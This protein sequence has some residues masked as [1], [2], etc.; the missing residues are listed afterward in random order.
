[1]TLA[2]TAVL[3][4]ASVIPSSYVFADFGL[5]QVF[6]DNVSVYVDNE[7]GRFVIQTL[8]GQPQRKTDDDKPLLFGGSQPKTSFTTFRIDGEDF[9]YGNDYGFVGMDSSFVQRPQT[10]GM[11][12]HSVW[13]K[14]GIE[15]TQN[16]TLV[17]D[18][19]NE[20]LG[21]VKITYEVKN[22][23]ASA[24]SVGSRILL[25]T[26]MGENDASLVT[27]AGNPAY[28]E[29]ETEVTGG[30]VPQYWRAVE[31]PN[32]WF[33][34]G[35]VAYGML[36]GWGNTIPD[37]LTVAHWQGIGQ[38]KWE[39][40]VDSDVNFGTAANKY[41]SADSAVAM[42]WNPQSLSPGESR[43]YETYYGV[44]TII[45]DG[46]TALPYN[47]VLSAPQKLTVNVDKDDYDDGTFQIQLLIDNTYKRELMSGVEAELLLPKELQLVSGKESE[48]V[49]AI[50]AG[51]TKIV[52]WTVRAMPQQTYKSV[53]YTVNVS[54][55]LHSGGDTEVARTGYVLLPSVAGA[56]PLV[57]VQDLLPAKK[58]TNDEEQKL[59]LVGKGFSLFQNDGSATL[60]LNRENDV[61]SRTF[62]LADVDLLDDQI[63]IDLADILGGVPEAGIYELKLNTSEF[64]TYTRKVEFTD[65]VAYRSRNY[66]LLAVT[67]SGTNYKLA[68]LEDEAGLKRLADEALL[69]FRGTVKEVKTGEQ[70]DIM[71]GSTIN[72]I[73]SFSESAD[74]ENWF[75][76]AQKMMISQTDN[77]IEMTGMGVLSIPKF[78]FTHGEFAI[79]LKNGTS[80]S[81]NPDQ[82]CLN[83]GTFPKPVYQCQEKEYGYTDPDPTGSDKPIQIEWPVYSWL[84][85]NKMLEK[86]P[87]TLKS[88]T[89]GEGSVSFGGSVALKLGGS[90]S[91]QV[92]HWP[93]EDAEWP[94]PPIYT[95]EVEGT[96][97]FTLSVNMQE[98]R[99]GM[100]DNQQFGLQGVIANGQ[101]GMPDGLVPGLNFGANGAVSINTFKPEY[102]I[103]VGASFEV[104]EVEGK[105]GLRFDQHSVPIIDSFV[106]AVGGQPGI[107]ITPATPVAYLTKVGGGFEKLYDTA[108]GNY[109]VIPPL[110]LIL[111]G[112][113]DVAKVVEADDMRLSM[114][115]QNMQFN[116][117]FSIVKFP[118]LNDVFGQIAI[119]DST[120][121]TGVDVQVG[122]TLT[123]FEIINGKVAAV[124]SY[125]SRRSGLFGPVYVA[126]KGQVVFGLPKSFP[127]GGGLKFAG[128]EAELSSERLLGRMEIIG[129]KIGAA[130]NWSTGEV[131]LASHPSGVK[132]ASPVQ[133]ASAETGVVTGIKNEMVYDPESGEQVG[134][135]VFGTNL[136]QGA[137]LKRVTRGAVTI[138]SDDSFVYT[139]NVS[140]DN[141]YAIF[142]LKYNG[143]VP[144]VTVKTPSGNV[145]PLIEEQRDES[146]TITQ[147]GNFR[148][149]EIPAEASESG[150]DEQWMYISALGTDAGGNPVSGNAAE[151]GSWMIASDQPLEGSA[152]NVAVM[153]EIGNVVASLTDNR[154]D[155]TWNATGA[156]GKKVALYI[157][158]SDQEVPE[159]TS[160]QADVSRLMIA[161]DN[162]VLATAGTASF[163]L[164]DTL[165]TGDYYVKAVLVDGD[166]NLHST[167]ST[168][169]IAY[170]N[171]AAPTAPEPPAVSALGNGFIQ[172]DWDYDADT[173]GAVAGF[174]LQALDADSKP[175]AGIGASLVEDGERRTANIGGVFIASE[176]GEEL[177]IVPGNTYKVAVKAYNLVGDQKVYG[178]S[179]ISESVYIPV[180]NPPV[181][182]LSLDASWYEEDGLYLTNKDVVNLEFSADQ[183]VHADV[184]VNDKFRFNH[185]GYSWSDTVELQEDGEHI[186]EILVTNEATGDTTTS[187]LHVQRDMKAPDLMIESP[188]RVALVSGS[189]I[190]VRGIAEPASVVTVNGEP[191]ELAPNG[192]FQTKLS[193]SGY[194][195][196]TVE[197]TATDEAGNHSEY[198]ADV[199]A[200]G[201]SFD[202]IEARIVGA[203]LGDDGGY[204]LAPGELWDMQV[205]SVSA[206]G[207]KRIIEDAALDWRTLMGEAYGHVTADGQLDLQLGIAEASRSEGE[208]VVKVSYP[209]SDEYMLEDALVIKVGEGGQEGPLDPGDPGNPGDHD[210]GGGSSHT[211][212]SPAS[213]ID[214]EME[215]L[216]RS[217]IEADG[218]FTYMDGVMLSE[219]GGTII[220]LDEQAVISLFGS[221]AAFGYG[222]AANPSAYL[223]GNLILLSDVY[224][225]RLSEPIN[226]NKPALLA[227]RL[228]EDAGSDADKAG[229]YWYN[230]QK[231]RWEYVGGDHDTG[232]AI[233]SAELPYF[234]KYALL[235][236]PERR[237]FSDI[238]GRWSEHAV[239]RLASIDVI[240]GYETDEERFFKPEQSITRQEF[241]KLLVEADSLAPSTSDAIASY[242]DADQVGK[243]AIP[244]INAALDQDWLSGVNRGDDLVLDPNREITRAEAAVLIS[245]MLGDELETV[246]A[247]VSFVDGSAVPPWA[248]KAVAMMQ[249]EK[250]ISGYPDGT[251]RPNNVITREEAAQMIVQLLDWQYDQSQK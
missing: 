45:Y 62:S 227:I 32:Q 135:L 177:G 155:V 185:N 156:E 165:P 226:L 23:T 44:G 159:L 167:I 5:S 213:S 67:K 123:V 68:P 188:S 251:F 198:Q 6:N 86:L 157:T 39:Y 125:D 195:S 150:L 207:V 168:H 224:D 29:H 174:A 141:P 215:D 138:A 206:D 178:P 209:L 69:V 239:Y 222:K 149:Q 133:I 97:P 247:A 49:G 132:G 30:D 105:L 110:T 83:T 179:V 147:E 87:V 99:F 191:V 15:V 137:V 208:L 37:R 169:P 34:S 22:T 79:N 203:E 194:F 102:I 148:L 111:I 98:A 145:Y 146:G 142:Q 76:T 151:S 65:D 184:F 18:P 140:A 230:E 108:M 25:D 31:H 126:G 232:T 91:K 218:Y 26:Q 117:D 101:V 88:V 119:A 238:D 153:P 75:G 36:N 104:V 56:P 77:G 92:D 127:V 236:N 235:I 100:L 42:Y 80:Y 240:H 139:L 161:P 158:D 172:V 211:G 124:F 128:V 144:N 13:Q 136:S 8:D 210:G 121:Y 46:D 103:E 193:M 50:G 171:T 24:V 175:I 118:I 106:F 9:I 71:P 61:W 53:R 190:E 246:D 225:F 162:G 143:T 131:K 154:V 166:L 223:Y 248:A 204:F 2:A 78:T 55:N 48:F 199:I 12:N 196:R 21:N 74:V 112:G 114:S 72:S 10:I 58:F 33:D 52:T 1:M 186:I 201:H 73:V 28:I 60:T 4:A 241:V 200:N 163:T 170:V 116:G 38:T 219:N 181:V 120:A 189:S 242:Q 64:G 192:T 95:E 16:F 197:V 70:F 14:D 221:G 3:L 20:N 94:P 35:V 63:T 93:S 54:A 66:G 160:E 152:L 250:R 164:P 113:L 244:Y 82:T 234:S 57:Q 40:A 173:H 187:V 84:E 7:T 90:K 27:F 182:D 214:Q 134:S 202:R 180:P 51:G 233:V 212:D 220:E 89:I 81:L 217:L 249:L 11:M 17:D 107:P 176:T 41:E 85:N 43:I 228:Q 129:M 122:A 205:A 109:E 59:T 115:L 245:R 229:I 96:D 183:S 19:G 243:W 130:Y 231:Q 237:L 216:L 47:A